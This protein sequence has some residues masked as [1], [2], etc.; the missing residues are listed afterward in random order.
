M[1]VQAQSKHELDRKGSEQLVVGRPEK[2]KDVADHAQL[3]PSKATRRC[4]GKA[5]T[6]HTWSAPD[7]PWHAAHAS[8]EAYAWSTFAPLD[9]FPGGC[10]KRCVQEK[11]QEPTNPPLQPEAPEMIVMTVSTEAESARVPERAAPKHTSTCGHQ[12]KEAVTN[13][14][15][16]DAREQ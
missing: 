3:C 12:K 1:R 5:W 14:L 13:K 10:K 4:P 6:R 2:E 8:K 15:C 9:G 7:L 11:T 16:Q